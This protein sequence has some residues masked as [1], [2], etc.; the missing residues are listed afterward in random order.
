MSMLQYNAVIV[1]SAD[2]TMLVYM[3]MLLAVLMAE[4]NMT[5]TCKPP[6]VP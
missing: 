4:V 1:L 3:K 6:A 5:S 2:C